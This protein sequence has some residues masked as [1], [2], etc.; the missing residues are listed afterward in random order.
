[1]TKTFERMAAQGDFVIIRINEIP[2]GVEAI[3]PRGNVHVIAHSET[4]HDHVMLADKVSCFK[5]KETKE[6]DLYELFLNVEAPT[7]INH[8]RSFDTHESLL[9]P[10]GKY[11]IRRQRE[12]VPQ[13][14]RRATD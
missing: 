6:V 12:Y 13:G 4:G 8:L 14:F 5:A 11:K 9:V 2:D 3:A 1:M 7:E 10:A